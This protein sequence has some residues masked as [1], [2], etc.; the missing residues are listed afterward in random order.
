LVKNPVNPE[1]KLWIGAIERIYKAGITRIAAIHRGFS[2]HSPTSYRNVPRWEIAIELKRIFPDLEMLVDN[3]HICGRRDTLQEVAQKALDLNYDGIMTEVHPTP[4]AAWSDAA[5]QITPDV[6]RDLVAQLQVRQATYDPAYLPTLEHLRHEI[7]ELDDE[8]LTLLHNRMKLSEQIGD[9][10][11]RNNIAILQPERWGEILERS[12]GKGK[13]KGLTEEFVYAL[14]KAVHEESINTQA[15][16][17]EAQE[18][19]KEE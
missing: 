15:R 5:Q 17:M 4:D 18:I 19:L 8:L 3:S 13:A 12:V 7:D 6:F 11:K 2:H 16:V 14:F 1:L 10:K 9:Y